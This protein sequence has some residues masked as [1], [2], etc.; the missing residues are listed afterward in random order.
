MKNKVLIVAALMIIVGIIVVA[1]KGFNVD[2]CYKNYNVISVSLEQDFKTEDV[3]NMAKDVFQNKEIEVYKSGTYSDSAVLKMPIFS[4][5][6]EQRASFA[7]KLNEKYG[8]K[9]EAK[10]VAEK[11]VPNFKLRD[12]VKQY[13]LFLAIATGAL[14]IYVVLKYRKLGILKVISQYLLYSVTA[15]IFFATMIA[16]TRFPI[17]KLVMP[18]A[19]IIYFAIISFLTYG[20]EKQLKEDKE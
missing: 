16:I 10:D 13:V 5:T 6:D 1:V 12:M 2:N 7:T 9:L 20:F 8:L 11:Y 15:E 14:A 3:A 18:S 17:N 19:V 4:I